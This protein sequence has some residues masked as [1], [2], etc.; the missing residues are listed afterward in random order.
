MK[1]ERGKKNKTLLNNVTRGPQ[2][3]FLVAA[4]TK[5]R[6][7][8]VRNRHLDTI[9]ALNYKVRHKLVEVGG[10]RRLVEWKRCVTGRPGEGGGGI[11]GELSAILTEGGRVIARGAT[12]HVVST[13]GLAIIQTPPQ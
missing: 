10:G 13:S 8:L 2:I 5:R 3:L 6:P 4:I 1:K 12:A 9:V 11:H 7:S